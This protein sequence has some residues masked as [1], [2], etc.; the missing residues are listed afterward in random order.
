MS[1]KFSKCVIREICITVWQQL[2]IDID[3]KAD[4]GSSPFD[5]AGWS[6]ISTSP[7]SLNGHAAMKD[8]P[9]TSKKPTTDRT[10]KKLLVFGSRLGTVRKKCRMKLND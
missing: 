4:V 1:W 2:G 6:C 3:T 9:K 10:K 5:W 8:L 7:G